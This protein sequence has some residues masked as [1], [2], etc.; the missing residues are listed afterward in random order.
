MPLPTNV[1]FDY[2]SAV[3]AEFAARPSMRQLLAHQALS[4]LSQ[5]HQTVAAAAM[6]DAESL[7]LVIPQH[8]HWVQRPLVESLF[9]AMRQG[10][11]L[12]A[13]GIEGGEFLVAAKPDCPFKDSEGNVLDEAVAIGPQLPALDAVLQA[14]VDT[15]VQAQ[16]DY[17]TAPSSL[18][19]NRD[20]WLQ[21]MIKSALL[22]N[23]PLQALD[24]QQM[25]CIQ[26]MLKGGAGRPSVFALEVE[27]ECE[28]EKQRVLSPNLLLQAEY[29][30]RLIL[31]WCAPSSRVHA[32]D[33]YDTFARGVRDELAE[34][35]RFD[36]LTLHRYELEGD[37]FAQQSAF[38]LEGIV[39]AIHRAQDWRTADVAAIDA[40]FTQLSDP[41]PLFIE[42]YA[43]ASSHTLTVPPGLR[44]V[45]EAD[46]FACQEALFELALAQ[47]ESAGLT[48]RDAVQ[49]L[50][51]YARQ[52]LR[53][54][55][56]DDHPDDAN[57]FPDDL[58]LTLRLVYG[59]PGGGGIGPGDGVIE[60]TEMTLTEYAVGRLGA[61][62]QASLSAI[63]HR[64]D[65]LIMP[66]LT[67]AYVQDLV[68]RVDIGGHPAHVARVM[69]APHG[70]SERIAC[71][72]REW[73]SALLFS[74]LAA[75]L[76]GTLEASALQ[77]VIDYCRGQ[78]DADDP[79]ITL[80]PLAFKP[81]P[82]NDE[83]D[84]V[85][86]MYVLLSSEPACV[87]LYRPL[88]AQA[89]LMA[90]ASLEALRLAISV[91]G[92]LQ[93]SVLDWLPDRAR[94]IYDNGG[95][96]EPHR[97]TPILDEAG[98]L[99]PVKPV[100]LHI[101][102][103]TSDVDGRLYTA[104][105]DLIVALASRASVSTAQR[106]WSRL[107]QGA[108]LLFDV[109]SLT[110][111]GPVATIAWLVQGIAA[112]D[113]DLPVLTQGTAFERSAAVVDLII[114]L[115]LG[116]AH[117]RLPA[118]APAESPAIA[119]SAPSDPLARPAFA[120]P[121]SEAVPA[122]TRVEP[123]Q[124]LATRPQTCLAFS[125][126]GAQGYNVLTE[127]QRAQLARLQA[128]VDLQGAPGQGGLHQI[129]GQYYVS[130]QGDSYRV[131][132]SEEGVRIVGAQ[133]E[134]GPWLERRFGAW[135][136]DMALRL[137]GGMPK[138]RIE[139]R[140]EENRARLSALKDQDEHLTA[141]HN[142]QSVTFNR[143]RKFLADKE[144]QVLE[145]EA[146]EHPD[147]LQVSELTMLRTLRKRI[148]QTVVYDLKGLIDTA[149]AHD[150]LMTQ[151]FDLRHANASLDEAVR[152][153][154]QAIRQ[155]LIE[156]C[157]TFYNEMAALI[158]EESAQELSDMV[159]V[160]PE[161]EQEIDQYKRLCEALENVVKWE[162]D[163]IEVALH[164]DRLLEATLDDSTITF[165]DPE[166]EV[167]MDKVAYLKEIVEKRRIN[168]IDL[169]F[170]MLMDLGELSI[171]RLAGGDEDT[172]RTIRAHLAGEAM[173][174]AGAA[175]GDLAGSELSTDERI[176]VLTGVLEAYEETA[177]SVDYLISTAPV[178]IRSDKL[179]QYG[180]VLSR[181]KSLA[182]Q[183]LEQTVREQELSAPPVRARA[184][185]ASRGGKRRVVKT[186]RGRS[187]V[188]TEVEIDGVP[189]LQQRDSR[190]DQVIKTF[191]RQGSQWLEDVKSSEP[192][193]EPV[194]KPEALRRRGQKLL[195][196]VES[197]IRLA[198]QYVKSDEPQGLSSIIDLHVEKLVD[199]QAKLPRTDQDQGLHAAL[200]DGIERLQATCQDLLVGLYLA[201]SHPT[202]ASL[203]FL[204]EH[205]AVRVERAGPRKRLSEHDYL[206]VY[207]IRRAPVAG[208]VRGIGLWEAHFHYPDATVPGAA[209]SKGHLK[210]WSQR[211]L[212][213]EAQLRAAA[214]GRD[215]LAIYRGDVKPEDVAGLIPFE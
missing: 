67:L 148:K 145:L 80:M 166:T 103:W 168:A 167:V 128:T 201:T 55:L 89:P 159:A 127:A 210:L 86:G 136:L 180:Q 58:L 76:A 71:F 115:S 176:S 173:Q 124:A 132:V 46:S 5:A 160:L 77:C 27:L 68:D 212:G 204:V 172:L 48:S 178:S 17:W 157:K 82:E 177:A 164:F 99:L 43:V 147:E 14:L 214:T 41:A 74:A 205:D 53:Q 161:S 141:Q 36:A 187:V 209:F 69:D 47:A 6:P 97:L 135:R 208:Q 149:L 191:K 194:Q 139:L 98:F 189:V 195:D 12:Q 203:R 29:D 35:Y 42:G 170:R 34:R 22:Q 186:Q 199:V 31:L 8:Q 88:H 108:W 129:E 163:L 169:E 131:E 122:P 183:T 181:L 15:F 49:S 120:W 92:P 197:V 13:L 121:Y 174:S 19:E 81:D 54:A 85:R 84:E 138:S 30:E 117:A 114:N 25:A 23:L 171:D 95:F 72:A 165:H 158:N 39:Q 37:P 83:V 146:L 1:A 116:I 190:N 185:Y 207:E 75:R 130:M 153:Q 198:R 200:T 102:P 156:Y 38:V 196:E 113:K 62:E 32:F 112:L 126:R 109:V 91:S 104:N 125:W 64:D 140:R 118:E 78:V 70:K 154:R 182:E 79:A 65:Q 16:L 134:K 10:T 211:K 105:R 61:F 59:V 11:S 206:E 26:G 162:A 2:R 9:E 119:S 51:D 150:R 21:L 56:L 106:R 52:Q 100:E 152:T 101:A 144:A 193:A 133:G 3:A 143:R 96:L 50:Q 155:E 111:R 44:A 40:L 7:I 20:R 33:A 87:L 24:A 45:K 184:V 179:Q 202:A 175:H 28:G 93:A 110:L 73:R 63:R 151:I 57:Y 188:G 66:W 192:P 4:V 60:T 90:F 137:R 94:R 123:L 215:L 142:E 213:R 107:V 18:G